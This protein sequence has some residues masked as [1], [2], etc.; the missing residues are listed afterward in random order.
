[1]A[2]LN[3]NKWQKSSLGIITSKSLWLNLFND[4]KESV[5]NQKLALLSS[6]NLI[7]QPLISFKKFTTDIIDF[8]KDKSILENYSSRVRL[9][10]AIYGN[11]RLY[12]CFHLIL[13]K[14]F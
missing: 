6:V 4:Y 9:P 10:R 12:F 1:M 11:V 3:Y 5:Y 13:G 2:H 7:Q 8:I 14:V